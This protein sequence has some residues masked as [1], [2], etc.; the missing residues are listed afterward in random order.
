[1]SITPPSPTAR[2]PL[3]APFAHLA[4]SMRIALLAIAVALVACGAPPPTPQP[5]R[6][7]LAEAATAIRSGEHGRAIE[8][9]A[10]HTGADGQ[11]TLLLAHARAGLARSRRV[12]APTSPAAL[13]AALDQVSLALP[14]AGGDQA[15]RAELLAAQ[16]ELAD[17]L[18]QE[19]A[20]RATQGGAAAAGQPPTDQPPAQAPPSPSPRPANPAPRAAQPPAHSAAQQAAFAVVERKS[21]DGSGNSGTFASCVDIQILGPGGPVA[22]A[23]VGINNGEH[24]YQNQTDGN[25]YTGRCGLGASTWSIVLFWTPA[26][27]AVKGAATTI[28]VNGTP[29]QRAAVVF[30][31]R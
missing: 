12:A 30:K 7:A 5:A 15:L 6:G 24:S 11:V 14:L 4:A 1:M 18:A 20:R 10:P 31:R 26:D 13:R 23:V 3:L 19:D 2:R 28:Y 8:L 29:E 17:L 27:G 25:G 16:Q 9:L 22:G 21:Y